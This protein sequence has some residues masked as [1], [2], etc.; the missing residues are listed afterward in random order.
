MVRVAIRCG[1]DTRKGRFRSL[2]SKSR[3]S[4]VGLWADRVRTS[5]IEPALVAESAVNTITFMWLT[6]NGRQ[7]SCGRV[8]LYVC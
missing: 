1:L 7:R 6:G 4:G 5:M 2:G 8:S 3:C